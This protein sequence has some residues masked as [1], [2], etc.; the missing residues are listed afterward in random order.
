MSDIE[1]FFHY[2]E[3]MQLWGISLELIFVNGTNQLK[4]QD[5]HPKADIALFDKGLTLHYCYY[6]ISKELKGFQV[7]VDSTPDTYGFGVHFDDKSGIARAVDNP[8]LSAVECASHDVTASDFDVITLNCSQPIDGQYVIIFMN[9]RFDS[10]RLCEVKVF[11]EE[12]CGRPLGMAT[13][14]ILDS[15]ISASSVDDHGFVHHHFNAR[16]NNPNA[17]CASLVDTEKYIQVNTEYDSM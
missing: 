15:A 7:L 17:W 9:N 11:G 10:L 4:F 16:L 13:E 1:H 5:P 3:E 8:F 2:E 14:E 6:D 12:S